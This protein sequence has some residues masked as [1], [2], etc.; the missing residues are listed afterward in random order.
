[1]SKFSQ[2][3]T[4]LPKKVKGQ[5]GISLYLSIIIMVILLAIVLGI[6]GILLGQL[7][8]MKG[9]ENSVIAFYA[10]DTGIE[11]VLMDRSNPNTEIGHYDGSV[12]DATYEVKVLS[13]GVNCDAANYCIS[14]VGTYKETQRAIQVS[15]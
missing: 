6:S 2:P 12:G 8:M 1:M 9:I 15:Y 14:S 10:A 7:K 4:F 3:F 13:S 5:K 11:K